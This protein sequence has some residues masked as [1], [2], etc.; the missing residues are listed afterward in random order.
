MPDF[1]VLNIADGSAGFIQV[2]SSNLAM[3]NN[4]GLVYVIFGLSGLKTKCSLNSYFYPYDRQNCSIIIGSWQHDTTRINFISSDNFVDLTSLTSNPVWNLNRVDVYKI[5]TGK[6]F[7]T[8][9]GE[10]SG[11]VGFYLILQRGSMYSMI[12]NVFPCLVLNIVVLAAYFIPMIA[13][14]MAICNFYNY[15]LSLF[16]FLILIN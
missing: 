9:F 8:K 4:Q 1:N 3:V 10:I 15:I 7:L 12:N 11:D 13:P 14:Q 16:F 6:R 5:Y 2:S